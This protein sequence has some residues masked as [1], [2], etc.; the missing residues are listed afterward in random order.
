MKE[1][2]D[3]TL[4]HAGTCEYCDHQGWLGFYLCGDA[5]TVVLICIECDTVWSDPHDLHKGIPERVGDPPD[6]MIERIGVSLARGRDATRDEI[7]VH[8]WEAFIQGE[9]RYQRKGKGRP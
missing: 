8:G 7:C 5:K 1:V 3:Y 6:F 9:Y 2:T 4:F